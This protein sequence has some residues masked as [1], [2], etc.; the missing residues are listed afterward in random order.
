MA[1]YLNLYN[2]EEDR[3][4]LR[5]YSSTFIGKKVS[6]VE[7]TDKVR[8]TDINQFEEEL[9]LAKLV[10]D[11]NSIINITN[12]YHNSQKQLIESDVHTFT[13]NQ[14][15]SV[16]KAI[17]L[18]DCEDIGEGAFRFCGKLKSCDFSNYK[19][20]L[21]AYMF[22]SCS[23]LTDIVFPTNITK[24]PNGLFSGCEKLKDIKIPNTV[25]KIGDGAFGGCQSLTEI[26]LPDVITELS[27]DLFGNCSNLTKIKFSEKLTKI[28]NG[29]FYKCGIKEI[30]LPNT[31][32]SIKFGAFS[33][34]KLQH[35]TLPPKLTQIPNS[36]FA[37]CYLLNSITLYD[38]L[39]NIASDAFN[40]C[41]KLK[42]LTIIGRKNISNVLPT[43]LLS[44]LTE[45]NV[46]SSLVSEYESFKTTNHYNFVVKAN[47]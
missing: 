27:N 24:L 12:Q 39:T 19:G 20:E 43:T 8:Y 23:E 2:R 34:S 42:K 17:I 22:A 32:T 16:I 3:N 5:V 47:V 21:G 15:N 7:A 10:L 36:C 11:D 35:I 6:Y 25:A 26:T 40:F 13:K 41:S 4:K 45:L 18:D 9:T 37:E 14:L 33:E 29:V 38:E 1:C 30:N 31:L 28:G 44:Q 46:D